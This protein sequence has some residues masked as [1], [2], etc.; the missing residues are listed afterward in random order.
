MIS[1]P[2]HPRPEG[3][4]VADGHLDDDR[5]VRA[6]LHHPTTLA[7]DPWGQGGIDRHHG[8]ELLATTD[9]QRIGRHRGVRVELRRQLQPVWRAHLDPAVDAVDPEDLALT[10]VCVI[11]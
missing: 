4:P 7:F 6:P 9:E 10:P 1:Q 5:P 11:G 2:E 3:L 8:T